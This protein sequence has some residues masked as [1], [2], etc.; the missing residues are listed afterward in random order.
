MGASAR[1]LGVL[2]HNRFCPSAGDPD[3][4]AKVIGRTTSTVVRLHRQRVFAKHPR[5]RAELDAE[6]H[7]GVSSS[8]KRGI[9][10]S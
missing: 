8:A 4:I 10:G 2:F 5:W 7:R 3:T 9:V 6:R 1:V